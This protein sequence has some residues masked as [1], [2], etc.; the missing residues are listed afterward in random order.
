[1]ERALR[2]KKQASGRPSCKY[3]LAPIRQKQHNFSE[4][5]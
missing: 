5:L 1:M 3:V 4:Y 2:M